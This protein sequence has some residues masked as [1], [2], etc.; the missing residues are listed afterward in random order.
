MSR[1]LIVLVAAGLMAACSQSSPVR[2]DP[3][4]APGPSDIVIPEPGDGGGRPLT[5]TLTTEAEVPACNEPAPPGRGTATISMNPG[6]GQ[7]CWVV[8]VENV[9]TTF[10]GAHIHRAPAGMAGGIVIPITT[11]D[12]SGHSEGCTTASRE[13]I[14]EILQNPEGFYLNVHNEDCRPGV[15]RGQLTK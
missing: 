5:A 1:R 9:N 10:T 12:A 6:L 8:D 13:L 2:P 14:N 4:A 11:P 3:A 15:A 7:V